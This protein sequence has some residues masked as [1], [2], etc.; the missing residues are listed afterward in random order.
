M[1]GIQ[2]TSGQQKIGDLKDWQLTLQEKNIRTFIVKNSIMQYELWREPIPTDMENR[3]PDMKPLKMMSY[4]SK[5]IVYP[6]KNGEH[7]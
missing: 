3:L 2:V 4:N 5:N 7:E 1:V 6:K